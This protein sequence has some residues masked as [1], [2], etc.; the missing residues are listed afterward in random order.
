MLKVCWTGIG[1]RLDEYSYEN[2]K[3]D[4][5]IMY[6]IYRVLIVQMLADEITY[7]ISGNKYSVAR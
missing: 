5:V 1:L 7:W 6:S 3:L 4:M 2:E